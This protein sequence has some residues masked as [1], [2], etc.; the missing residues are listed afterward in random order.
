MNN[1]KLFGL[2]L[3][4]AVVSGSQ[5]VSCSKSGG[6]G[7]PADPCSG[8]TIIINANATPSAGCGTPSGSVSVT[9]TGSTGF[10][11]KINNAGNYQASGIF[12]GLAAGTYTVF[13]KD[14]D[15]CE[16]SQA[17]TVTSTGG[18]FTINTT[19][20][21]TDGCGST[22]GSITVTANGSTGFQYKLNAAGVYGAANVFNNL[23]EGVY[24]VFVKDATGCEN[25]Q[26]ITVSAGALGPKFSAVRALLNAKCTRCHSGP[27]P[28]AG[29]DWTVNCNV[30]ANST[31]INTRAV[32]IGDM[33]FGGPPLSTT[34]KAIITDWIT[35]GGKLTN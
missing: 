1:K 34:E 12:N 35:A 33:P 30:V 19:A 6:Y 29:R 14:A 10:Q 5:L 22:S 27:T 24:T 2:L 9:A 15:G 3:F 11:Y 32:V 7:Q 8:K 31:L 13:V 23:G 17:V 4:A 18:S 25:S 16:R 28:E 21:T 20:T 26:A